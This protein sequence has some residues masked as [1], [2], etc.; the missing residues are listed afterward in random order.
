MPDQQCLKLSSGLHVNLHTH[1]CVHPKYMYVS[2]YTVLHTNAY[3]T[4]SKR[5][6]LPQLY[7]LDLI[8][9][10]LERKEGK[11]YRKGGG[12]YIKIKIVLAQ[13]KGGIFQSPKMYQVLNQM[14]LMINM[15]LKQG[16]WTN[17]KIHAPL[18]ETYAV[19]QP[20]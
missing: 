18:Q 6:T 9:L 14:I 15:F 2:K 7:S 16:F 1:L 4:S 20:I 5:S 13:K 19:F 12:T 3:K 8:S 17:V 11:K 10:P